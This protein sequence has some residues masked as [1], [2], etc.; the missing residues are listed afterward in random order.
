MINDATHDKSI[1]IGRIDLQRNFSFFEIENEAVDK[2][3]EAMK[4]VMYDNENIEFGLATNQSA[5]MQEKRSKKKAK[6]DSADYRES[7]PAKGKSRG[8]ED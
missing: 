8:R 4:T 1:D 6:A 5:P 7:A 2:V 3:M